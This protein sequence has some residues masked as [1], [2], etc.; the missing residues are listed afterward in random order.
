MIKKVGAGLFCMSIFLFFYLLLPRFIIEMNNP[1]LQVG[2]QVFRPATNVAAKQDQL[3]T[4]K[5]YEGLDITAH[6]S[7]PHTP[8][9]GSIILIHGIAG[10]YRYYDRIVPRLNALGYQTIAINLRSHGKSA[11]DFCTFGV[12]EHKDILRIIDTLQVRE[13]SSDNLAIWGHS[14]GG[15]VALQ[16]LAHDD[17]VRYG[18][19]ESTFADFSSVVM[20]YQEDYLGFEF[21]SMAN[22]LSDRACTVAG[23]TAEEA[24][25]KNI[26][27]QITQPILLV[28][29]DVDQK[30]DIKHGHINFEAIGSIDKRFHIVENAGHNN[31]W[32]VGGEDYWEMAS[33][34][35]LEQHCG[36]TLDNSTDMLNN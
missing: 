18:I 2:R 8:R 1:V 13:Q 19:V 32:K 20:A 30:I 4:F 26:A 27:P 15:A 14:L 24:S 5:G 29:G 16:V 9:I 17:R 28:H 22:Y 31:V 6:I 7:E 10:N 11:G 21:K 12:K 35:L 25:P 3:T 36:E 33:N 34:F 23:F